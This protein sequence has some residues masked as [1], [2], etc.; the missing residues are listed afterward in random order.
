[1]SK[2]YLHSR[3][4]IDLASSSIHPSQF[5]FDKET[6]GREKKEEN[7]NLQV[8]MVLNESSITVKIDWLIDWLAVQ[9]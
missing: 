1:M 8:L 7:I 4:R 3:I 6:N 2:T 5:L 9:F